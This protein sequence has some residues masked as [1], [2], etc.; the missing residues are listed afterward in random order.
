MSAA[1]V[2]PVSPSVE[3]ASG[4]RK[5]SPRRGSPSTA[6]RPLMRPGPRDTMPTL[7][8]GV[9]GPSVHAALGKDRCVLIVVS[10]P[11]TGK[12][13]QLPG[14]E[15]TVG[16]NCADVALDD[17]TVSR[18]HAR[19]YRTDGQ[20]YV[21]D[22]GSSN[23]TYRG[24]EQV[25]E[26]MR[27]EDGDL[28]SLG[29]QTVLRVALLDELSERAL[30]VMYEASLIDGLTGAYNRRYFDSHADTE[31]AFAS[32]HDQPLSVILLDIDEFKRI[33]DQRGHDVGD[34]VLRVI[35]ASIGRIIRPGDVFARYGGDEFVVLARSLDARNAEILAER[36]RKSVE[37]ACLYSP[38]GILRATLSIGVASRPP[39]SSCTRAELIGIADRAMYR[40]KAAGR[41]RVVSAIA[42]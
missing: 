42:H 18:R 32:R 8:D 23:G 27:L 19:F 25:L 16:R 29:R 15:L 2:L 17:P 30:L 20:F 11:D 36:I 26:P 4:F 3:R 14:P 33:N 39:S 1:E 41:N 35:A 22:L 40:A 6:E 13:V 5:P 37:R 21:E 9:A 31:I 28:V 34:R 10:G 12:M 7:V 24:T 38:T